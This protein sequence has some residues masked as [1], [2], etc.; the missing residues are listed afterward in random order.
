MLK[1]S[2]GSC[3]RRLDLSIYEPMLS[4]TVLVL[5][6]EGHATLAFI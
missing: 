2:V 6:N 1:L 4:L 3:M 5:D